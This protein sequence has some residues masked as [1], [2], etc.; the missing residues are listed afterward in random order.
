VLAS[1]DS[2]P[3]K[4][5]QPEK[6]RDH[7]LHV[8]VEYLGEHRSSDFGGIDA[9]LAYFKGTH[10][11]HGGKLPSRDNTKIVRSAGARERT[12]LA[13]G[14]SAYHGIGHATDT[15]IV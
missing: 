6:N 3:R 13:L 12:L 9:P 7:K 15:T 4:K 11:M 1:G 8:V 2:T 5:E 10:P 14:G